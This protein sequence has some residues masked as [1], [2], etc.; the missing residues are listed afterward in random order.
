MSTEKKIKK[1]ER[2]IA[3]LRTKSDS[4]KR[5]TALR[6]ALTAVKKF[7][8][9]SLHELMAIADT[10]AVATKGKRARINDAT[11]K[12]VVATLKR[13]ETV[14]KTAQMHKISA[15]TVNVIKKAAGL[16]KPRAI[17]IHPLDSKTARF[18]ESGK[19]V[20]K[21]RFIKYRPTK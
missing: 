4:I 10:A 17:K 14:A 8:Y 21:S 6:R 3:T 11:R 12:S 5:K 9:D 15:P 20:R 18:T 19:G 7:G 16:T 2:M 13:G 1:L